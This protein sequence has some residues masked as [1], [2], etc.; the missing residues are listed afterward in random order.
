MTLQPSP[1]TALREIYS[2]SKQRNRDAILAQFDFVYEV[3][4]E[5][6]PS[7]L[8]PDTKTVFSAKDAAIIQKRLE[9]GA[10]VKEFQQRN[11]LFIQGLQRIKEQ[12]KGE[13]FIPAPYVQV[14]RTESLLTPEMF[15]SNALYTEVER[16]FLA[17]LETKPPQLLR[18]QLGQIL[19]CAIRYGGLLNP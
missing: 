19:L 6:C 15:Q 11:R 2:H 14:K 7:L 12:Y 16:R 18:E 13:I 5:T 1:W 4:R 9:Q 17:D 8:E 3:V 10:K